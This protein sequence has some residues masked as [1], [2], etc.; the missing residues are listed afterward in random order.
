MI[1]FLSHKNFASKKFSI[2]AKIGPGIILN[3][4]TDCQQKLKNKHLFT[5][6]IQGASRP[7]L[8]HINKCVPVQ[9]NKPYSHTN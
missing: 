4:G 5:W 2:E 1:F 7:E 3:T 9:N 6:I 8:E